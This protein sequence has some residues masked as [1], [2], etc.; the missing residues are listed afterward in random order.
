MNTLILPFLMKNPSLCEF[1]LSHNYDLSITVQN[2]GK[3]YTANTQSPFTKLNA[4]KLQ[5]NFA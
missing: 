3:F 1:L 4:Y 2:N 5:L